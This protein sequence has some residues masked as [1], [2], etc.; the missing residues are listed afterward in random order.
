MYVCVSL[1]D[2]HS[3]QNYSV[4][5]C[6]SIYRHVRLAVQHGR[7]FSRLYP[8]YAD[9]ANRRTSLKQSVRRGFAASSMT[10]HAGKVCP[11]E[12]QVMHT[13]PARA[14]TQYTLS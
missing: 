14:R 5:V 6:M 12:R 11:R 9:C 3:Y 4:G 10:V 1:I 8:R 2:S 7:R 13:H